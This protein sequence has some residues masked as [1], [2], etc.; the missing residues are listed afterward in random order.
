MTKSKCCCPANNSPI[1]IDFRVIFYKN[2][3]FQQFNDI[4]NYINIYKLGEFILLSINIELPYQSSFAIITNDQMIVTDL[5]KYYMSYAKVTNNSCDHIITVDNCGNE[6]RIKF[7]DKLIYT[8]NPIQIIHN[9]IFE[10]RKF[11]DNM[12][13]LHG[14]GIEHNKKAV[15]FL[16]PTTGGKTTL[17]SFLTKNG[18]RYIS[19]DSIIIGIDDFLVY[20]LS[21]P[22]HL[23]EGGMEILNQYNAKPAACNVVGKDEIKRYTYLP[24]NIANNPLPIDRIYFLKRSSFNNIIKMTNSEAI[25]SLCKSFAVPYDMTLKHIKFI[26]LL[27]QNECYIMN[28]SDM[29][30]ILKLF[31]NK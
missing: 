11:N 25:F 28:Y 31:E 26:N 6:Y 9:I 24:D 16:A 4:I 10:N 3:D 7:K 15:I 19:D 14:A 5:E 22:I 8:S 30:Y 29:N 13:V 17:I 27:S 18:C 21:L 1:K 20:P 2:I 23:R 12:I